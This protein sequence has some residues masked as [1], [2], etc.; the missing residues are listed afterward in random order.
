VIDAVAT[1]AGT[2]IRVTPRISI[3]ALVLGALSVALLAASFVWAH[4]WGA[5][6]DTLIVAWAFATVGALVFSIRFYFLEDVWPTHISRQLA[7]IGIAAASSRSPRWSCRASSGPWGS[8]PPASVAAADR[9]GEP[10]RTAG[11]E[12]RLP[13]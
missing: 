5:A 6:A 12:R 8:T 2:S 11:V 3:V 9:P 13:G 4:H 10:G 7:G 1:P